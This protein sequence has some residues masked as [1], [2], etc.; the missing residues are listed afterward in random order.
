MNRNIKIAAALAVIL[1]VGA[2]SE[3][4]R[5]SIIVSN[6]AVLADSLGVS[7]GP[8]A[9]TVDYVVSLTG[10]IYTYAYTVNNP[11]GDV[12]L[13]G[14]SQAGNPEVVDSFSVSFDTLLPGEF[15]SGTQVGGN[16]GDQNNGI[17]GLFWSFSGIQPGS[18]IT[19]S[20]ES[21]NPPVLGN[22][23]ASDANPPSPWG[24]VPDGQQVTVPG[25]VTVPDG[26]STAS[27]LGGVLLFLPFGLAKRRK[28]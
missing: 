15:I 11:T 5:A 16:S 23:N 14:N 20:F 10:G 21:D 28:V 18:S 26:A 8:E 6:Q 17:A 4:A 13:P 12:I 9:L 2:L 22:A 7:S 19:L 1:S 24:S 25:S 3:Q 27:L